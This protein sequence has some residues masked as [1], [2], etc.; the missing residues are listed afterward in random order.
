MRVAKWA[1]V[2]LIC[3][4]ALTFFVLAYDAVLCGTPSASELKRKIVLLPSKT[5]FLFKASGKANCILSTEGIFPDWHQ[6]VKITFLTADFLN[7]NKKTLKFSDDFTG[8]TIE[9]GTIT[10]DSES[11]IATLNLTFLSSYS[12]QDVVNGEYDANELYGHVSEN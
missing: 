5:D 12:F 6:S 9:S 3:A 2:S 1:I 8:E 10:F 4:G 7:S 11:K